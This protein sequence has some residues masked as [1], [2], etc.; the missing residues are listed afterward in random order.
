LISF[1]IKKGKLIFAFLFTSLNLL[2][3][4]SHVLTDDLD[5]R[6]LA[7]HHQT[8]EV[9]YQNLSRLVLNLLAL[10]YSQVPLVAV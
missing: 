4:F 7:E 1:V 8:L 2:L 10:L 9:H 5:H 3:I 6:L